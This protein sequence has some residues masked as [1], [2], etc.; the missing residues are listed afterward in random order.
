MK[1]A[2][3]QRADHWPDMFSPNCDL[4]TVREQYTEILFHKLTAEERN[5]GYF[6]Q[7]NATAHTADNSMGAIRKV[8]DDRIV[9]KWPPRS[10]IL[11]AVTFI[12]GGT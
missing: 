7:D 6:Q 10:P 4:A 9:S 11:V 12:C 2:V 8:F 1:F 3:Q 5:Y